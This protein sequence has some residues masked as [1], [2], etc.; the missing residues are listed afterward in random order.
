[1]ELLLAL[2]RKCSKTVI[3]RTYI[4]PKPLIMAGQRITYWKSRKKMK[5][6]GVDIMKLSGYS[7]QL[8]D[9]FGYTTMKLSIYTIKEELK[10]Y[11]EEPTSCTEG[12]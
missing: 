1:M 8:D 4:W 11:L 3:T 6:K 5:I 2:Q 12:G 10:A 7:K 9:K